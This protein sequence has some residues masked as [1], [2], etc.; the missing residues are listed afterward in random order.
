LVLLFLYFIDEHGDEVLEGESGRSSH[1][2]GGDLWD[3]GILGSS[4]LGALDKEFDL[5]DISKASLQFRNDMENMK[6]G[7]QVDL[8]PKEVDTMESLMDEQNINT[9]KKEEKTRKQEAAPAATVISS[10]TEIKEEK[11]GSSLLSAI[12]AGSV[13]SSSVALPSSVFELSSSSHLAPLDK[14]L[15]SLGSLISDAPISSNFLKPSNAFG[16][17]LLLNSLHSSSSSLLAPSFPV[18]SFFQSEPVLFSH[19]PPAPPVD[20]EW[21]YTDPQQQIQGPFSQENMRLWN[22]AGYFGRDLPIKLRNWS[23]FHHFNIVFPDARLAFYSLPQEPVR[24]TFANLSSPFGISSSVDRG[25]AINNSSIVGDSSLR[26]HNPLNFSIS[27]SEKPSLI[28]NTN[29]VLR[30]VNPQQERPISHSV[31]EVKSSVPAASVVTPSSKLNSSTESSHRPVVFKEESVKSQTASEASSGNQQT[32]SKSDLKQLLG[33]SKKQPTAHLVPSNMDSS[34]VSSVQPHPNHQQATLLKHNQQQSLEAQQGAEKQ[35]GSKSWKTGEPS[36]APKPVSFLDIQHEAAEEQKKKDVPPSPS[37]SGAQ[38]TAMSV[39]LKSL[40]GLKAA[41]ASTSSPSVPVTSSSTNSKSSPWA[42]AEVR[43]VPLKEIMN[44]EITHQKQ[45]DVTSE[46]GNKS[47]WA[48]K[49]GSKPDY[50]SPPVTSSISVSPVPP[51]KSNAKLTVPATSEKPAAAQNP[52]ASRNPS[53]SETRSDF[54]GK[55]MSKELADWSVGQLRSIKPGVDSASLMEFCMSLNSAAEIRET[56]STYLG[57]SPQVS[58]NFCYL[59]CFYQL[60]L[61]LGYQFRH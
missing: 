35:Q 48:A 42:A 58:L 21:F 8:A 22:E 57:S 60:F 4:S 38:P 53:K 36:G 31:V 56:L 39:Q 28:L 45:K 37:G 15:G 19:P 44:E 51:I 13:S 52:G 9:G 32:A 29:S 24:N 59:F 27:E 5:T 55:K 40:L 34:H 54:G 6:L 26:R 20:P 46:R 49:I 33:I 41:P 47:S 18:N 1:H 50:S 61:L 14:N 25:L 10:F 43:S 11:K 3:D 7:S 12:T 17:S 30:S 23:S 2:H 16:E